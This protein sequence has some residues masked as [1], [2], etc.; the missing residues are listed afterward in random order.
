LALLLEGTF[1][2]L[3]A[4]RDDWDFA[5]EIADLQLAGLSKNMIRWLIHKGY[6]RQAVET[7]QAIGPG[8][9]QF[10]VVDNLVFPSRSCLVL[11]ETGIRFALQSSH[12]GAATSPIEIT[13]ATSAPPATGP[14][15]DAR[16]RV[17]RLGGV[18][19]KHF[20]V[21]AGNQELVLSAFQEE[22][23]P[24]T[25]DDPL[26][27]VDGIDAKRRLHDTINRLNRN[28]KQRMMRFSGNGNG[29]AV[30][31]ARFGEPAE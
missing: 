29:R 23:W 2:T 17:L 6:A 15:W 24:K 9:R 12:Q 22:G 10:Q 3:D 18:V 21:P 13:S 19:V 30:C 5:V 31:W 8:G 27:P 28:Q 4:N 26:P 11:S 16:T 1:L 20:K 14:Q 7:T 25:I